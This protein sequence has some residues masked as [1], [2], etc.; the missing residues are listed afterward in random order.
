[1]KNYR[2]YLDAPA[3]EWELATPVGCGNLGAMIYGDVQIER[4]QL[5][6]E[7]IWAGG[8]IN[9]D[10]L[11]FRG[12]ID[13]TRSLLLDGK[14]YDADLYAEN[15]LKDK[16]HRVNSY[17]TAGELFISMH[18]DGNHTDFRRELDL[19]SGVASIEYKK[20]GVFYRRE[21]FASNP[22]QVI[23]LRFSADKSASVNFT[24]SFKRE[25]IVSRRVADYNTLEIV[26][27][28]SCGGH[29][30]TVLVKFIPSAGS[31]TLSA[32]EAIVS[33]ADSCAVYIT[34]STVKKPEFPDVL[35]WDD[36]KKEH[37]N[38]FS[39]L[40]NRSDITLGENSETLENLP[41]NER[42]KRVRE[43]GIDTG[44]VELYFQFGKYLLISSSRPGSLPANLQGVWN[45]YMNAPW[46]SDYHTNI[47][48]QMNYWHAET[49]NISD[50][51]LP[52]FDYINHFLLESGK[53][54]ASVNYR[55]RGTVLHHLSD[56][57]GF[58]APADG[59]W[60][61]WPLGGAWLCY[62]FW[63]HYLYTLDLF[64]LKEIA[65]RYISECVRF[66][67]DAMYET[68]NGILLSGPST[69]PENRY[70]KDGKAA[71]LCMSPTMDVEIISGLF[72]IYIATETLLGINADLAKEAETALTKMPSLKIGKYGQLM[73]WLEDYDEP[74]PG[75][76]HISHMFALYP[77]SAINP[78]TPEFFEAARK[79][80]E[81]RLKNGGGHTGWSCAWLV[82]LY[83]RL[84]DGEN[85][86]KNLR[87][88]FI[89]STRDNLFDTHPPFQIDGNFGGCAAIAEMLLQSHNGVIK[90]LPALPS[91]FA[92]GS[93]ERLCVRGGAE[94]WAKW[95]NSR[96]TEF[97]IL[98]K[99]GGTYTVNVNDETFDIHCDAYYKYNFSYTE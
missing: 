21:L 41:I 77:D 32:D 28:T 51:V 63:E 92:D 62:H 42:L 47:N 75:H 14:A 35:I 17:E 16:F 3:S 56:I 31:L 85:A 64:F 44:L 81:R 43:G 50:C 69:S 74:E 83:A 84:L 27:I 86:M 12:I 68:E 61:L 39:D 80:L 79:T 15:A 7:C 23:A 76:R 2:I 18:K 45:G 89:N 97:S 59:L 1:M 54:T 36:L 93:F 22:S 72:R 99:T 48:L 6:E 73:E 90:F 19:N 67:L 95:E 4:L 49:T 30:F 87:K 13:K 96:I 10:C 11:D 82:A 55:C 5:N 33:C 57:Y 52:L 53:R 58:T 26:G 71:F 20:D 78:S 94:I 46:N 9:T 60:G 66:F 24:A 29:H 91:C 34:A 65:Y 70:Y 25:N 88:L 8:P 98:S 38:D 37:I 40:M